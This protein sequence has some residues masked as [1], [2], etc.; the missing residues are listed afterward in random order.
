MNQA[1]PSMPALAG[2]VRR[3][4]GNREARLQRMFP[5]RRRIVAQADSVSCGL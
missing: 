2:T 3:R 5:C 1:L 4:D